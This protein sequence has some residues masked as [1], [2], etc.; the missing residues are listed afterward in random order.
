MSKSFEALW[1]LYVPRDG[2]PRTAQGET[3]R[4]IARVSHEVS[5]NECANWDAD[6]ETLIDL[7]PRHLE[8]GWQPATAVI[9]RLRADA[10]LVKSH[11][12][13][14]SAVTPE[15]G[16]AIS[17]IR[18]VVVDWCNARLADPARNS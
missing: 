7:I 13:S 9:E 16:V 5:I 15:V 1:K 6:Y 17:R 4:A 18:E 3:L 12:S 2:A 8:R 11:A 14:R 10:A